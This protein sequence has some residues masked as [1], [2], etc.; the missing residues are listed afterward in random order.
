MG[1]KRVAEGGSIEVTIAFSSGFMLD[2][3]LVE[4]LQYRLKQMSWQKL[5]FDNVAE[6]SFNVLHGAMIHHLNRGRY[7]KEA[8]FE[9]LADTAGIPTK[10][11]VAWSARFVVAERENEAET[12]D[13]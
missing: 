10:E 12:M 4:L 5:T 2:T 7:G 3:V 1:K 6:G 13:E 8:V 9:V 11:A